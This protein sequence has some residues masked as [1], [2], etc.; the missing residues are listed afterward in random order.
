MS[1][2]KEKKKCLYCGEMFIPKTKRSRFC[3]KKCESH[4]YCYERARKNH[5][6]QIGSM[7]ICPVCGK[8]FA[9]RSGSNR[10]CSEACNREATRKKQ[11]ER[12]ERHLEEKRQQEEAKRC[13]KSI[14]EIAMEAEQL[15]LSY[16][17]LVGLRRIQQS[18]CDNL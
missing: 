10:Y 9:K 2:T 12:R 18:K 17:Q 7:I 16:G 4:F 3:S 6:V 11:K 5:T 8:E 1:A 13:A 14:S 15:G